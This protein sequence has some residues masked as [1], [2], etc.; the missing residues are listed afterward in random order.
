ML[1]GHFGNPGTLMSYGRTGR[2]FAEVALGLFVRFRQR[3][4]TGKNQHG[5]RRRVVRLE[6]LANII[7]GRGI[8]ILHRTDDGVGVGMLGRVSGL[9][10]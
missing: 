8:E 1:A 10:D 6:P 9:D 3:D 2:N 7:K 4:V 5:I